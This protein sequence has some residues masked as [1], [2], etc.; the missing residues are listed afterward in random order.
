MN[1]LHVWMYVN[2]WMSVMVYLYAFL[3]LL[4][5]IRTCMHVRMYAWPHMLPACMYACMIMYACAV[6]MYSFGLCSNVR[7]VMIHQCIISA[8]FCLNFL[9]NATAILTACEAAARTPS[10]QSFTAG[11]A[12]KYT[13]YDSSRPAI[14]LWRV[15]RKA[16]TD[17][18]YM[19]LMFWCLQE[20]FHLLADSALWLGNAQ[21]HC[22]CNQP[23]TPRWNPTDSTNKTGNQKL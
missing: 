7:W 3:H 9:V 23:S 5:C 13:W 15:S 22:K 14:V 8:S 17:W 11:V 16:Q 1:C 4:E 10:S 20:L 18:S 2:V 6:C 21:C 12:R 19:K